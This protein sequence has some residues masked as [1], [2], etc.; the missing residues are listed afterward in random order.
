MPDTN[1]TRAEF[2]DR[3]LT[4]RL[5]GEVAKRFLFNDGEVAVL[6]TLSQKMP[7][8][9]AQPVLLVVAT[10]PPAVTQPGVHDFGIDYAEQPVASAEEA[11][12]LLAQF[13]QKQAALFRAKCRTLSA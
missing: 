11:H 3:I 13:D 6:Y 8:D 12:D 2:I 1:S 9:L 4:S 10:F 7:A 5:P